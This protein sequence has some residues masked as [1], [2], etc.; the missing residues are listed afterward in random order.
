MSQPISVCSIYKAAKGDE[1]TRDSLF[2]AM[3]YNRRYG[4][5]TQF[6]CK[7]NPPCEIPTKEQID[8]LNEQFKEFIKE[9]NV[10]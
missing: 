7:C 4:H 10:S 5:W 9:Q 8:L 1:K 2:K 6:P 3:N